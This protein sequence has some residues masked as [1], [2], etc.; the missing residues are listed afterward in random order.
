MNYEEFKKEKDT[1]HKDCKADINT[2]IQQRDQKLKMLQ[3][4]FDNSNKKNVT[5]K[6]KET[7]AKK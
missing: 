6:I 1:I 5:K 7:L 4:I 2:A 3:K